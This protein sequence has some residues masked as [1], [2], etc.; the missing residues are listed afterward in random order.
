[1]AVISFSLTD[2]ELVR[3]YKPV[4]CKRRIR[5][6]ETPLFRILHPQGESEECMTFLYAEHNREGENEM[7]GCG[8]KNM[9]R[10]GRMNQDKTK[11]D[12][13]ALRK[14]MR[15]HGCIHTHACVCVCAC[16]C[17]DM[18]ISSTPPPYPPATA[19]HLTPPCPALQGLSQKGMRRGTVF[20]PCGGQ[21]LWIRQPSLGPSPMGSGA[22]QAPSSPPEDGGL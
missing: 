2:F 4:K 1:M 21:S 6:S 17:C 15:V 9:R 22:Q 5:G 11:S 19:P 7:G 10:G 12:G 20:H 18:P 3:G 14:R 13:A 8:E 16:M